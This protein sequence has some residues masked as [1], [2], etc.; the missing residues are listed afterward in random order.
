MKKHV[1]LVFFLIFSV[2]RAQA[3][4]MG[5]ERAKLG[6]FGDSLNILK[7]NKVKFIKER[8]HFNLGQRIQFSGSYWFANE[9]LS[10]QTIVFGFPQESFWAVHFHREFRIKDIYKSI[11]SKEVYFSELSFIE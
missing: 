11:G 6:A 1:L 9:E 7:N 10:E 2:S 5:F 8:L 4:F 3:N